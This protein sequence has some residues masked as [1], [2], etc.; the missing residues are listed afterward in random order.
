MGEVYN[1][2]ERENVP[3]KFSLTEH[4]LKKASRGYF[5]FEITNFIVLI[6][7]NLFPVDDIDAGCK[8]WKFWGFHLRVKQYS[9][10]IININ[11]IIICIFNCRY[12]CGG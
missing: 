6:H 12:T 9:S 3:R 5:Y 7:P 4:T 8:A 2:I 1:N 11:K 10:E